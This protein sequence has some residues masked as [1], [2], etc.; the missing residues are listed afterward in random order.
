MPVCHYGLGQSV[1]Q[2][3]EK[4][5]EKIPAVVTRDNLYPGRFRCRPAWMLMVK[6]RMQ[7]PRRIGVLWSPNL[8]LVL[9]RKKINDYNMAI[10]IEHLWC[11]YRT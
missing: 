9:L 6:L 2:C 1:S 7:H 4:H 10:I 11:S 8:A 3:A 5:R